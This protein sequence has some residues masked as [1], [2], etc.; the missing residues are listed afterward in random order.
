MVDRSS[1]G[2][3]AEFWDRTDGEVQW[4]LGDSNDVL[5]INANTNFVG[6]ECSGQANLDLA[7][8]VALQ[9]IIRQDAIAQTECGTG[10]PAAHRLAMV[11]PLRHVS[12]R[13]AA[14]S[15]S[16]CH[17]A[18]CVGR[19]F[20]APGI[21]VRPSRSSSYEL[22]WTPCADPPRLLPPRVSPTG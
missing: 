7:R 14:S 5:H 16:R 13:T 22:N 18:P 20:P 6:Y 19:T 10:G 12:V 8:P 21:G 2:F 17:A 3:L 4:D 15:M 11:A 1:Q 9:W